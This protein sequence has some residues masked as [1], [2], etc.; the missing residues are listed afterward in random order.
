MMAECSA[1]ITEA[2]YLMKR[3]TV[4]CSRSGVSTA[5]FSS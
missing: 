2:N 4:S 1:S 3:I 5:V